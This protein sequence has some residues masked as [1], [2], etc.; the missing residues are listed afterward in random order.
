MK[1]VTEPTKCRS[2]NTDV[3]WVR[4]DSGKRMPVDAVADMRPPNKGGGN[5][6]LTLK[7]GQFGELI[8]D[9]FDAAKHDAKGFV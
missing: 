8:C 3:L 9:R 1:P 5:L 7:G 4:W 6:V 2:C